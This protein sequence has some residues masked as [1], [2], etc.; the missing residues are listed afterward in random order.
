MASCGTEKGNESA[1]KVCR[2]CVEKFEDTDR[3]EE[4]EIDVK[5]KGEE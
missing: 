5:R 3:N 2:E 1:Q 4:M